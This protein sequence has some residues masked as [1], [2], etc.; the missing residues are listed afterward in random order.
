MPKVDMVD[1]IVQDVFVAAWRSLKSYSG[2][3]SLQAWLLGIARNKVEDHYR[4]TLSQ[5]LA[6]LEAVVDEIPI[7]ESGIENRLDDERQKERAAQVLAEL[8]YEY[9]IALRWRYWEGRSA[10]DVASASGRTEKA[11]ERLLARARARFK[12]HWLRSELPEGR[13]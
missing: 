8:P 3:A 9:A 1:D 2:E 4:R 5:P 6:E 11:V 10:R 13:K 12:D 7:A